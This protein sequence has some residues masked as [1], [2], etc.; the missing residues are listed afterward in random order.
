MA[1]IDPAFVPVSAREWSL[2]DAAA[3]SAADYESGHGPHPGL[4]LLIWLCDD[5]QAGNCGLCIEDENKA[6]DR[7]CEC[8]HE[9]WPQ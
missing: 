9:E 8:E 1:P 5:C 7:D 4:P 3:T 6:G 2:H